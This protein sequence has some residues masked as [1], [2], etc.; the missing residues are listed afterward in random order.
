MNSSNIYQTEGKKNYRKHPTV[1][2]EWSLNYNT[3]HAPA[4]RDIKLPLQ[5]QEAQQSFTLRLLH[6]NH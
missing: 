6:T 4:F 3:H 1:C 5:K 2:I